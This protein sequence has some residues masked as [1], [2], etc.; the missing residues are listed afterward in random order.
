[1]RDVR[2]IGRRTWLTR[3]TG[4]AIAV[5]TSLSLSGCSGW[6]VSIGSTGRQASDPGGDGIRR[7]PLGQN[8][9]TTSYIV[10]RGKEAAIVDTGV[11]GSSARIGEVVKGAGLGWDAVR[12]LIVTHYHSDHAGSVG[13]VLNQATSATVWAGAE[14]IPRF[15]SPRPVQAAQDGAEVFGLRVIATPGHT[16]GHISVYDAAASTFITGDA[17][18]NVGSL[19]SS[20]P[21][22]T[23][24]MAKAAESV[25]K[26]AGLTFERAYFMHGEP[27]EEGASAQIN[28]LA[29]SLP[30]D[31]AVLAQMAGV[32]DDCCG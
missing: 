7:V 18:M 25:R 15:Q 9:F 31:L 30:N 27:I 12:H 5:W 32:Q 3:V 29:L 19:T 8:G 17:L 23:A 11:G 28:A 2:K 26:I 13:E 4:G 14:D 22:F 24:D 1:M 21:Q 16:L 6:A 10:I 20:P